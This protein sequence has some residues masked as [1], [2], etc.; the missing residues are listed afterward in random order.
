[1]RFHSLRELPHAVYNETL[2][3]EEARP[4]TWCPPTPCTFHY[5]CTAEAMHHV[6]HRWPDPFPCRTCRTQEETLPT[7][8]A[9]DGTDRQRVT[10]TRGE[11]RAFRERMS[12]RDI[13]RARFVSHFA[14]FDARSKFITDEIPVVDLPSALELLHAYFPGGR[15]AW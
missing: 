8:R 10:V 4:R 14:W 1:M 3:R 6:W 11:A 5:R 9:D 2:L 15:I 7:S 13:E 12:A